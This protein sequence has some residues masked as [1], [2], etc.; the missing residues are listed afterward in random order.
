MSNIE[1]AIIALKKEYEVNP[2][3]ELHQIIVDLYNLK[4]KM[5]RI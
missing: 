4:I 2:S 3:P 5:E 1:S